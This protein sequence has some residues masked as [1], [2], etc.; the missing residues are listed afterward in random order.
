[1]MPWRFGE[2][3]KWLR[4]H[5]GGSR[6]VVWVLYPHEAGEKPEI[7]YD[8][9]RR[10]LTIRHGGGSDRID[11]RDGIEVHVDGNSEQFLKG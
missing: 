2:Y 6:D 5:T 1:E 4:V 11:F 10:E 7:V 9:S 8:S 3:Q